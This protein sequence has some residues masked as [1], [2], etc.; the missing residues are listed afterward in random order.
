VVLPGDPGVREGDGVRLSI[1]R[2]RVFPYPRE[3]LTRALSVE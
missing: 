2:Y 3:G 1:G